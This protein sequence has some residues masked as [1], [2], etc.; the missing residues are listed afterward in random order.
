MLIVI[1]YIVI[2]HDVFHQQVAI[3]IF[4]IGK[5]EP[6][7]TQGPNVPTFLDTFWNFFTIFVFHLSF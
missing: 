5:T 1:M 6:I 4:Q 7:L 2:M 3:P